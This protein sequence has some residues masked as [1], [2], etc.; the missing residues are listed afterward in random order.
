VSRLVAIPPARFASDLV[1]LPP[2]R[3]KG[4]TQA[5]NAISTR[6][7]IFDVLAREEF[8]SSPAIRRRERL[9]VREYELSRVKSNVLEKRYHQYNPALGTVSPHRRD[10]VQLALNSEAEAVQV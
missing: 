2:V 4:A 8:C 7:N 3:D 1:D 5:I 10:L 6:S 9:V